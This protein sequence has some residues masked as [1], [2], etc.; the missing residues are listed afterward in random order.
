MPNVQVRLFAGLQGLIGKPAIEM[1]LPSGAT[2]AMLRDR[3]VEEYPQVEPFMSTLV[4][5][6]DEEMIDTSHVLSEGERVELI[7]PIAGGA[8]VYPADVADGGGWVG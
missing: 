8:W 4:C 3:L 7:P 2:V 1:A 6:V 5:A